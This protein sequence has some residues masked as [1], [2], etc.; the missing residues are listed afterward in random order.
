[1]SALHHGLSGGKETGDTFGKIEHGI[2]EVAHMPTLPLDDRHGYKRNRFG[3]L[4]R[5]T[6]PSSP[7]EGRTSGP[8]RR[9]DN[10]VH[11]R[12]SRLPVQVALSSCRLA[13]GAS[14]LELS[15][16]LKK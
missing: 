10:G 6:Y 7:V 1:M 16:I 8:K 15:R 4:A 14:D 3:T 11:Q 13:A 2:G 5:R 9:I 12:K